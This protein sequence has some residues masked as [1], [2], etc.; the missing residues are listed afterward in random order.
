MTQAPRRVNFVFGQLLS[1]EDLQAEQDYHRSMRYLQN[2]LHGSGVVHGLDVEVDAASGLH[3]R[4]GIAIDALGRELVM[5]DTQCLGSDTLDRD[6]PYDVVILWGQL[7]GRT[8]P[9]PDEQELITQWIEQPA[10]QVVRSGQ[11][12]PEAVL[13]AQ[14]WSD[15]D[16]NVTLDPSVCR[17]H[18]LADQVALDVADPCRPNSEEATPGGG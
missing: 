8:V 12:P 5:T 3:V 13:L 11:G 6:Q 7:P 17:R 18:P 16:S 10:A 1:A 9:G 15:A 2:R 4:P 14:V